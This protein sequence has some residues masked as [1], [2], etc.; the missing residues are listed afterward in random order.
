VKPK[1]ITLDKVGEKLESEVISTFCC[2]AAN[3]ECKSAVGNKGEMSL[4]GRCVHCTP[5][6]ECRGGRYESIDAAAAALA[7]TGDEKDLPSRES[8]LCS[9]LP[10][11][12]LLTSHSSF[13]QL[14]RVDWCV[15]SL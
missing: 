6:V 3:R 4:K 8:R 9:R 13:S 2:E 1:N 15:R 7:S 5:S 12:A 10:V 14:A 11:P